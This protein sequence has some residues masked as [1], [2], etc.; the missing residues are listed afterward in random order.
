MFKYIYILVL[1]SQLLLFG[2]EYANGV[3]TKA[4]NWLGVETGARSI[5]MG[6]TGVA[7]G[8]DLSAVPYNPASI[9][10]INSSQSYYSKTKYIDDTSYNVLGYATRISPSEHVGLHIYFFDSGDIERTTVQHP[11]G[12][13]GYYQVMQYKIRAMFAKSMM[14]DRLRIGASIKYF[15]EQIH[16]A[17]MQSIAFDIG[18]NLDTEMFGTSVG[19]SINNIGP[20]VR[21]KGEG[22]QVTTDGNIDGV[23]NTITEPWPIPLEFK[24]GFSTDIIGDRYSVL[25]PSSYHRLTLTS[26]F[27]Q[28]TDYRMQLVSG[29]EYCWNN[30]AYARA[31]A[32]FG[33]DS[34]GL[35]FGFG[36]KYK[37][38][39]VDFAYV[40][41]STLLSTNQFGISLEF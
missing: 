8:T 24:L 39:M 20:D 15:R 19:L 41:Y 2:D 40:D 22:I 21:Y 1:L 29:A 30:I 3:A 23:A 14:S 7:S 35:S 6:G 27:T 34:A 26:D 13:I 33:H 25:V 18:A 36:L 17:N 31:G 10:F 5:A 16:T 9:S 11:D 12:G 32:R 4:G 37:G 38:I 28:A